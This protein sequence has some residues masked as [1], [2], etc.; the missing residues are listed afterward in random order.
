M[1]HVMKMTKGA[2]GHMLKHYERAKD[3]DG[4][5]IKFGNQDIDTAFSGMNYNRGPDRSISQW[6]FIK[7]RC[8][9]VYCM[10]RKDVNVMCSW[11]ITAPKDLKNDDMHRFFA[12]A[13]KFLENRYGK[14]N[15]ISA[16]VHMDETTPHMHFAF[17]PV[18]FD[19]KKQRY[20]VSAFEVITKQ[21]LKV[22]HTE[23]NQ[24]ISKELGYEVGILN[25][26][27][28]DG[29][30][31]ITELK[32][33]TAKGELDNIIEKARNLT[34]KA[35]NLEDG[36]KVASEQKKTLQGELEGLEEQLKGVQKDLLTAKQVKD[37]PH[38]QALFGDKQV[39]ATSDFNALCRTA[40]M[41]EALLKEIKPARKTNAQAEGIIENVKM[42]AHEILQRAR[43]IEENAKRKSLNEIMNDV[44]NRKELDR[45]HDILR[46]NPELLKA[47][48]EAE[49]E[50]N[51]AKRRTISNDLER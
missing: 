31:S 8:S 7:K 50:I 44:K 39:V 46:S 34:E 45:I 38:T 51:E 9:E 29:N 20:K 40:A 13:Y 22:F 4:N 10:N 37:V 6:E 47:F 48:R 42:K 30:K 12:S 23:L 33:G 35:K 16:Y 25:E 18:V 27:T 41:A 19:K 28:K 26:A 14:E 49:S 36:I 11:V 3:E 32:R 2:C 1:A 21:E 17:I 5:Y 24:H 43:E 15:I